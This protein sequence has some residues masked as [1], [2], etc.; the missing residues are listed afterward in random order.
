MDFA[1]ETHP[2]RADEICSLGAGAIAKLR[3]SARQSDVPG[4]F[5]ASHAPM[6][7]EYT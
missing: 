6:L 7:T 1:I 5:R 2:P 4:M 3:K